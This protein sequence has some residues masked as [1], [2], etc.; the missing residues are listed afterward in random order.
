MPSAKRSCPPPYP[1]PSRKKLGAQLKCEAH[2]ISVSHCYFVSDGPPWLSRRS[3]LTHF[4]LLISFKAIKIVK[5]ITLPLISA[6]F[7][8]QLNHP[9]QPEQKWLVVSYFHTF[10][11][12]MSVG[13]K[14]FSCHSNNGTTDRHIFFIFFIGGNNSLFKSTTVLSFERKVFIF[15]KMLCIL[16]IHQNSFWNIR[17]I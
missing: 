13:V 5:K 7:W 9:V 1:C 2:F 14:Y 15:R 3:H 6:D 4:P 11:T 17:H 16:G 10:T 12:G 8:P